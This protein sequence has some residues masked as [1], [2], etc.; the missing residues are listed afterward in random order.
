MAIVEEQLGPH[1]SAEAARK[2]WVLAPSQFE[3]L[4]GLHN[5]NLYIPPVEEVTLWHP[6]GFQSALNP[7]LDWAAIEEAYLSQEVP[8]FYF[9]NFLAPAALEALIK[10]TLEA[11][12]WFDV[13]LGYFG[14]YL[15]NGFTSP[16]LLQIAQE[17][18]KRLPK[19]LGEM[20]ITNIWAYKYDSSQ[21]TT[22]IKVHADNA[23]VN[24]NFW[25]TP[26]SANLDPSSGGLIVYPTLPPEGFSFA[27]FNSITAEGD[28]KALLAEQGV[29]D[30]AIHV[31]YKQNRC[32]MFDSLLL[33]ETAPFNFK[34]G[35][36]NRRINLTFL[37]SRP[38]SERVIPQESFTYKP[39]P[40]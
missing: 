26:D 20:V 37:F 31:P 27:D 8:V 21:D 17:L 40:E 13:K 16:W 34:N 23:E 12:V 28:I 6:T 22:G 2:V 38:G 14:A 5:S 7:Q 19:I 29:L 33:H 32:V 3:A 4:H 25:V 30:S 9:D 35:Y 1:D 39:A 24:L 11:S 36:E 10:Y 18:P 15:N